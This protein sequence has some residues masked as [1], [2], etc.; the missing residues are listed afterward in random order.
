MVSNLLMF[1]H[2]TQEWNC[3]KIFAIKN[4]VSLYKNFN[5]ILNLYFTEVNMEWISHKMNTRSDTQMHFSYNLSDK[6]SNLTEKYKSHINR[7]N[8]RQRYLRCDFCDKIFNYRCFS[9]QPI[10][11]L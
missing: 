10:N 4:G 7:I 6:S 11:F 5:I 3:I 2:G 1:S 9:E 8:E